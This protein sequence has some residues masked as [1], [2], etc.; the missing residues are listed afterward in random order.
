M[1]GTWQ[2][3]NDIFR[4]IDMY[5]QRNAHL[6]PWNHLSR[7]NQDYVKRRALGYV[8]SAIASGLKHGSK[9]VYKKAFAKKSKSG[10][11]GVAKGAKSTRV[12]ARRRPVYRPKAYTKRYK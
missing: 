8:V 10:G 11:K 12:N 1:S 2:G 9:L 6:N 7:R 5:E 3:V 4:M